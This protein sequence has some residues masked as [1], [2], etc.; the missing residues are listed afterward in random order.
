[1]DRSAQSLKAA[2]LR[3]LHLGP[4]GTPPIPELAQLGVRRVSIGSGAMRASLWRARSIADQLLRQGPYSCF[5]DEAV[6]FAE[7]NALFSG[8]KETPTMPATAREK[9][10]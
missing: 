4:G 7:M 2:A 9:G 8:L 10:K 6:S 3:Q 5:L 1:M